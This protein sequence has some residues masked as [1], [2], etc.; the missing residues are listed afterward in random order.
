MEAIDGK[1]SFDVSR[2][3]LEKLADGFAAIAVDIGTGDGRFV[4]ALARAHPEWFCIGIDSARQN[5]RE[6]SA[7]IHKKPSRG[8]LPARNALYVIANVSDLPDELTGLANRVYVN[9]PWGSL[10]AAV[11]RGDEAVL[12]SVGKVSAGGAILEVLV[13]YNIFVDPVPQE[14]R[15]LPRLTPHYIEDELAPAYASAGFTLVETR[16]LTGDELREIPTT[17]SKRLAYGRCP[18]TVYV[19]MRIR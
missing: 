14:V 11:V 8:G 4:Y 13:N 7:K 5:L 3:A 1:N 6:Y 15:E 9:F 2:A 10:L 16:T 19:K 17:W 18:D 12:R